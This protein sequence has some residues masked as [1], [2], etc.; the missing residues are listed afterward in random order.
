MNELPIR[1]RAKEISYHFGIAL[2]TVWLYAKE[3]KLTPIK[4]SER[5]TVFDRDEVLALFSNK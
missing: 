5:V 2:S 4:I 1:L 3:N